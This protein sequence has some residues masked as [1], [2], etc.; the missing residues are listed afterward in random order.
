MQSEIRKLPK[1][2]VFIISILILMGFVVF[3]LLKNLKELKLE[4]VLAK[5]GHSNIEKLE[6]INKL[7][8]EDTQTRY[9]SSVFKVTFYDNDL[10]QT[11][12][13]FVHQNRDGSYTK[14]FDCK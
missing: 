9:K 3:F 10:K 5:I 12:I 13:G 14:D 7:S 2:T 8:V 6:V 1:K 4:E 11:C